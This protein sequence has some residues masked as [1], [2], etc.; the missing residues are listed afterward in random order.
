MILY[1]D[2]DHQQRATNLGAAYNEKV[3]ALQNLSQ[4][5]NGIE[6]LVCSDATLT[7]WGHGS[8]TKFS[9]LVTTEFCKLVENWK[10]KNNQ[11]TTVEIVTCDARHHNDALFSYATSVAKYMAANKIAVAVKA[12]PIGQYANDVSILWANTTTNTFCYITAPS[13]ATLA[14]ANARLTYWEDVTRKN[15]NLN[16]VAAEMAKERTL[17][18]PNNFAVVG[19]N[20]NNLRSYLGVVAAG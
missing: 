9:T 18:A 10:K 6:A 16:L 17:A 5:S 2:Q 11:L 3:S 12:L 15:Y 13:A 4:S 14:Q 1:G 19:G 20:F 8:D 7:V